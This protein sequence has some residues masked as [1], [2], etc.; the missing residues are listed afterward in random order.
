MSFEKALFYLLIFVGFLFAIR[1]LQKQSSEVRGSPLRRL[2]LFAGWMLGLVAF[3]VVLTI[4][5]R[6]AEKGRH[7]AEAQKQEERG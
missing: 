3:L 5:L 6:L 4:G 7:G 2:G 1:K